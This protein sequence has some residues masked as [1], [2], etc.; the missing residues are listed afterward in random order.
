MKETPTQ[1]KALGSA[2][3]ARVMKLLPHRYPFLLV[4]RL[5]EMEGDERCI[6]IKS[7]TI[8]EPF[9]RGTFPVSRSCRGY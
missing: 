7:V 1:K 6:G 9:S 3:I 4:D 2:D 8:N 5:I